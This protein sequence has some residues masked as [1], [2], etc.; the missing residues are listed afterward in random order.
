MK[1]FTR[2]FTDS[3]QHRCKTINSLISP[4]AH[5]AC[6]HAITK[7]GHLGWLPHDRPNKSLSS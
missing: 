2:S 4:L 1:S 3:H 6:D 7:L 5:V